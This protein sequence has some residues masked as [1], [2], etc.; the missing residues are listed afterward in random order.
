MGLDQ[1]TEVY[2]LDVFSKGLV[3]KVFYGFRTEQ[4]E[5]GPFP[6]IPLL[7]FHLTQSGSV[8]KG[9]RNMQEDMTSRSTEL[10]ALVRKRGLNQGEYTR[11]VKG[12]EEELTSDNSP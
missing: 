6:D 2:A 11:L 4:Q 8:Q 10:K 7:S 12:I 9:F 1:T 5:L 3:T